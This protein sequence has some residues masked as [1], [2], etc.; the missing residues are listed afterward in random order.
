MHHNKLEKYEYIYIKF[1][2]KEEATEKENRKMFGYD[3]G[4][5]PNMGM[6]K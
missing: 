6:D 3:F 4:H 5:V 1:Q 2:V